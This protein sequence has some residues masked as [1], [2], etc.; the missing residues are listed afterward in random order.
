MISQS[1]NLPKQNVYSAIASLHTKLAVSTGMKREVFW[2]YFDQKYRNR[3]KR[4]AKRL[5]ERMLLELIKGNVNA[6]M[7]RQMAEIDAFIKSL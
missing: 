6:D 3:L 5:N 1:N 7:Q 2:Q 4:T